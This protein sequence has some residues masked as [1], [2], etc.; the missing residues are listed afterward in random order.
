M[1]I[2]DKFQETVGKAKESVKGRRAE[3][4]V[5]RG[6]GI[7]EG[8]DVATDELCHLFKMRC[9]MGHIGFVNRRIAHINECS[10]NSFVGDTSLFKRQLNIGLCHG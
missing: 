7:G 10:C 9:E 3:V 2:G 1:G 4:A 6:D 5:A 8:A